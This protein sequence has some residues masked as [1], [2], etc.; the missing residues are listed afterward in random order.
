MNI[1]VR[2]PRRSEIGPYSH[3]PTARPRKNAV[4]TQPTWAESAAMPNSSRMSG[5]AGS[6][7]SIASAVIAMSAVRSAMN[8][9]PLAVGRWATS[10]S[11][12]VRVIEDSAARRHATARPRR[13]R[14]VTRP[15][16]RSRPSPP[17]QNPAP[18]SVLSAGH[19]GSGIERRRLQRSS[20]EQRISERARPAV[21]SDRGGDEVA[22][23]V[24]VEGTDVASPH[25]A[26][27]I[28]DHRDGKPDQVQL[29]EQLALRVDELLEV[30]AELVQ[31]RLC[32]FAATLDVDADEADARRR[33][34]CAPAGTPAARSGTARTTSPRSS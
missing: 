27:G 29:G 10:V 16:R 18:G 32:R 22:Q 26:V 9:R 8:S 17:V 7:R 19:V 25:A 13:E 21:R 34:R 31:E 24:F 1:G 23:F 3:G 28:E 11:A 15:A 30:D 33:D 2:R 6:M 14:P 5:N 12:R 4:I 20:F